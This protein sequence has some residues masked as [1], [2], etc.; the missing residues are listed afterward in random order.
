[1]KIRLKEEGFETKW[2]RKGVKMDLM[3][4]ENSAHPMSTKIQTIFNMLKTADKLSSNEF[5]DEGCRKVLDLAHKNGYSNSK[6]NQKLHY[7]RYFRNVPVVKIPFVN[8]GFSR[9]VQYIF[10]KYGLRVNVVVSTPPTL[11]DLLTRS[12]LYGA[13]CEK[14]DCKICEKIMGKC[15]LKGVIYKLNCKECGESYI[16]ETGRPLRERIMEHAA[17]IRHRRTRNGP[18]AHH[19]REFHEGKEVDFTVEILQIERSIQ[20]RKIKEAIL[21]KKLNPKINTKEKR[22]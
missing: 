9:R 14:E 10:R 8:D 22:N 13:K 16:G 3:I 1:M 5:K 2:Y 20:L 17:D 18:W 15:L 21:I 19:C 6:I 4:R 12:R 7:T 11:K